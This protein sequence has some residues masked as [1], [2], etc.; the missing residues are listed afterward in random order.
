MVGCPLYWYGATGSIG[1]TAGQSKAD[2]EQL[3]GLGKLINNLRQIVSRLM[4]LPFELVW[5]NWYGWYICWIII[6]RWI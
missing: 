4:W 5:I 1:T 2:V 6:I 3:I